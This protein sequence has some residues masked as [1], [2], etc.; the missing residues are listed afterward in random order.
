MA[1]I[2][3][4]TDAEQ[5]EQA[6]F[7]DLCTSVQAVIRGVLKVRDIREPLAITDQAELYLT[8]DGKL[9]LPDGHM[10]ELCQLSNE[11]LAALVVA[12]SHLTQPA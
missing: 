10:V 12:L 7:H 6:I 4:L 3:S 2:G 11:E 1:P 5:T 8:S 9:L